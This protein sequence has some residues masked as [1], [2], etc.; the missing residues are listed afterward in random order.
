MA[1]QADE[2]TIISWAQTQGYPVEDKLAQD[3]PFSKMD[4]E[5]D[6][7]YNTQSLAK[8]AYSILYQALKFAQKHQVPI[9]LD[10]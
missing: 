9:T 7:T 3:G 2:A 1:W 5:E 10:Y 8:F 4:L 6:T